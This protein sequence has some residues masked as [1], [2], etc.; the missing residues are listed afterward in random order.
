[1]DSVLCRF[2]GSR[3]CAM[4]V[5]VRIRVT[6]RCAPPVQRLG[7]AVRPG[8][9]AA[10]AV[11]SADELPVYLTGRFEFLGAPGEFFLGGE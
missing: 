10:V 11:D 6:H 4:G 5:D 1:M 8:C 7:A 9:S 2:L 3:V